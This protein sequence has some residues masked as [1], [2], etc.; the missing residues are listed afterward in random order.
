[1]NV[2]ELEEE[3]IVSKRDWLQQQL[4]KHCYASDTNQEQE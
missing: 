3:E 1:M 4:R 2:L